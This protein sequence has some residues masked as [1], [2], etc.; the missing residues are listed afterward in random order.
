[1]LSVSSSPV[2]ISMVF[3]SRGER[4]KE[5]KK[6]R[7]K[8]KGNSVPDKERK[9]VKMTVKN[10]GRKIVKHILNVVIGKLAEVIFKG[11]TIYT[12]DPNNPVVEAVAIQD[13]K[14]IAAGNEVDVMVFNN[15]QKTKIVDL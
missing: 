2:E 7:K 6:E 1:M 11:G 12:M 9:R 5:R 10:K 14:I 13:G 4:E 15:G 8:E 3:C